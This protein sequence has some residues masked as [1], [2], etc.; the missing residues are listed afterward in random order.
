MPLKKLYKDT[1]ELGYNTRDFPTDIT[2]K[3]CQSLVNLFPGKPVPMARDGISPWNTSTINYEIDEII[4]WSEDDDSAILISGFSFYSVSG[5]STVPA[6]IATVTGLAAGTKFRWVRV[7]DSL[8]IITDQDGNDASYIITEDADGFSLRN[9]NIANPGFNYI[10]AVRKG[11]GN[12]SGGKH[13]RFTI[14]FVN[15]NDSDSV[16]ANGDPKLVSVAASGIFHPGILESIP[17]LSTDYQTFTDAADSEIT[18]EAD[19]SVALESQVTHMRI[20]RTLEADTAVIAAGLERRWTADVPVKGPNASGSTTHTFDEN[21]TEA[22]M[23]GVLSLLKTVGYSRVP[24]GSSIIYHQGRIWIGGKLG[25]VSFPD[26]PGR[27]YYSEAPLDVEWPQKWLSMFE[28]VT[29]FKDTSLDNEERGAGMGVSD[30]D[31]YFIMEKTTVWKLRNGDPDFEPELVSSTKGSKYPWTITFIDQLL[32][33]LSNEGPVYIENEVI[34]TLRDFTA[35]EVWPELWDGSTGY[36]FNQTAD[37]VRAFYFKETWWIHHDVMLVGMYMPSK[38]QGM[39]PMRVIPAWSEVRF[40]RVAVLGADKCV[41]TSMPQ[42]QSYLWDFL[43]PTVK[44]DNGYI[45]TLSSKS[46]AFYINKINPD[47]AGELYD[48]LLHCRFTDAGTLNITVIGDKYRVLHSVDYIQAARASGPL[49]DATIAD[50]KRNVIQQGFVEGLIGR[51]VEVEWTKK[52]KTPFDFETQGFSLRHFPLPAHDYEYQ[53]TTIGDPDG[54]IRDARD[55]DRDDSL[56]VDDGKVHDAGDTTRD[57][58]GWT[59]RDPGTAE[60]RIS[61]S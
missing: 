38:A 25:D 1:Y 13:I 20:Y 14:T 19:T 55:T 59:I 29:Y 40:N 35:G 27:W 58:D 9:G 4:P 3:S 17:N 10:T 36:F 31:I 15:R 48:I 47:M 33:Y 8:Y 54:Y 16:D 45:M 18:V 11:A 51:V 44:K 43:D 41:S 22:T 5:D 39:G 60:T 26:R 53:G 49:V 50:T 28:I 12:V 52:Y 7:R 37:D 23:A 21:N 61:T 57:T 46:K 2:P 34:K 30:N 32:C 42:T 56:W 6:L 24:A